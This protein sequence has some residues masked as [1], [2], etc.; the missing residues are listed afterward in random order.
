LAKRRII[1]NSIFNENV[2]NSDF[3]NQSSSTL[4]RLG[5]FTLDTNLQNRIIGDFSNKI[6]SFSKEYT[7]ESINLTKTL[8]EEI[9]EYDSTLKLNLDYKNISSYARYGSLEELFK[10]TIKSIINK[11]PYSIYVSA[12]INGG[13]AN[14]VLNF[15]YNEIDDISTFNIPVITINNINNIIIDSNNNI[16]N[17]ENPLLNFNLTKDKYVI[18][19]ILDNDEIYPIIGFTGNTNNNLITLQVKGKLFNLINSSISKNYHIRPSDEEFNKFLFKLNDIER[20]FLSK[21]INE[22]Y[23]IGLKV[24]NKNNKGFTTKNLIW[25]VNDGYNI[26][27]DGT[28][29]LSFLNEL[30]NIGKKYDEYKTDI[31]YRLYTTTSLKEFDI[32]NSGKMSKLIR[33]YGFEFDKI[34]RLVDGFA[35][36]NNLTYKKEN[37]IPDILVK[38]LAKV[39]GWEIFDIVKEDDLLSK[40]FTV[41]SNEISESVIPSEIDIELWRRILLNTKWFFK[42]KGTRKSI[43]TI[44]KLIGIP[45]EFIQLNEYVYT[46]NNKLEIED[47]R[48]SITQ[49]EIFDDLTITNESSFDSDGYPIA[50]SENNEFFFQISGNTDNGKKYLDRFRENGFNIKENIDNKKS[51]LLNNEFETRIDDNTLYDLNDSKLLINTKEIDIG[52]NPSNAIEFDVYNFNKLTN[53]PICDNNVTTGVI[54]V[55]TALN[56]TTSSQSVFEIPDIPEGD[57]QVSINGITL[58]IND[59]YIIS[60]TTNNIIVLT[61]PALNILNGIKDIVSITYVTDIFSETRN[62]VEYVVTRIGINQNGQNIITLIDEPLGDLQ[63]VLNGI[64]LKNSTNLFDGDFYINPLNRKEIIIISS[65]VNSSLRTTDIVTVM[66]IKEANDNNVSKYSDSHIVTSFFGSKLYY[67]NITNRYIYVTDYSILNESSIKVTLNGITLNYGVDFI[68]SSTNK[69]QIIFLPNIII[70]I[71]DIINCFYFIDDNVSNTCIKLCVNNNIDTFLGYTDNLIKNLINVKNRKTITNNNG[72]IYPKLSLIY[73]IYIKKYKENNQFTNGYNYLDLYNY[74]KKFDNHF[75]KFLFQLLPATTI[76]RKTGLIISNPIFTRQKYRYIR[77]INDGSEFISTTQK[78]TCDLFNFTVNSVDATTSEN[79]GILNINATGFTN[80][81]EYSIDG[82]EFYFLNNTFTDLE[83]GEY[84]IV[85]K[86][87]I[88]CIVTGT[89]QININCNEFNLININKT[90]ITSTN[91]LGSIEII[92]SGDTNIY[93]S[94]DGGNNFTLNKNIFTELL[95][96]SYTIVIKNSL[97]CTITGSTINI[98][99]NCNISITDF[100]YGICDPT[101][102][103]SRSGTTLTIINNVLAY[104]PIYNFI[105]DNQFSRYFR[106]KVIITE[107]TTEHVLLEKWIEFEIEPNQTLINLGNIFIYEVPTYDEFNFVDTYTGQTISCSTFIDPLPN[108]IFNPLPEEPTTV[109][110]L[111]ANLINNEYIGNGQYD[112]LFTAQLNQTLSQNLI[113]NIKQPYIDN[114]I[115]NEILT[116]II[117]N[118]GEFIGSVTDILTNTTLVD[119]TEFGTLCIVSISYTGSETITITNQCI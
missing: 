113:V 71:N 69:N 78:L 56:P 76:S 27:I 8:S 73:D 6:S 75:T 59:D 22:G 111:N 26:N 31:I 49:N 98:V 10:H 110:T 119:D 37:S 33:T 17:N 15:S 50:V 66:Y 3:E 46:V 63:L 44:F 48:I 29:Y 4:F 64:T 38:N 11:Y 1:R 70:K 36:L 41:N 108:D 60:G 95:E 92:A 74:I 34:K 14:T 79:L 52:F 35:T 90:N 21:K 28:S 42:S 89:T 24:L 86:D 106:E 115:P 39:L 83:P 55:N 23:I 80:T 67:N 85:L 109:I 18:S 43:D 32:T 65:D 61:Q 58:T 88:G 72:G 107:T 40:I 47:R 54:Y 12:Q 30:I 97:D 62:I 116:T 13:L 94:I 9:Y 7:L 84:N 96:G 2:V 82:G 19:D 101:G 118:Q 117:I 103:I 53:F 112:L 20:Y 77:G 114:G 51:W 81:I 16:P 105:V 68:L 104:N 25:N 45:E 93:Y 99:N 5:S 57:I 87:E 100:E 102:F 91:D